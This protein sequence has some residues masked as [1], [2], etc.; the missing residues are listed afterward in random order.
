[1]KRT[2]MFVAAITLALLAISHDIQAQELEFEVTVNTPKNQIVDPKVFQDMENQIETF[3]NSR[4]WTSD[5]YE[6]NERIKGNIQLTIT[7]ELSATS[8]QADIAIQSV[9]PVYGSTIETAL[10]TH[11]DAFA[12]S[13]EQFQPLE[14]ADNIY[15]DHLTSVLSFYMYL[16]LGLD[17]DSF[18]PLG[19]DEYFQ[20]AQ[21]IINTIPSGVASSNPGWRPKDGN[22]TRFTML[23]NLLN[24]RAKELRYAM[25][26]YHVRG[27]DLMSKSIDLGRANIMK[28][29][30]GVEKVGKQIPNSMIVQM[31]FNAKRNEIIDIFREGTSAEKTEVVQICTKLDPANAIKYRTIQRG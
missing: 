24:P 30:E 8:F 2:L 27:L 29:I 5:I 19:G 4:K 25:Y 13:Y 18:E 21:N 16:V 26:D 1:M 11:N 31:F 9:R 23:D 10:L 20:K 22:R 6:Q 7:E 28:G 12:F 14:F 3:I 17:Y 15:N